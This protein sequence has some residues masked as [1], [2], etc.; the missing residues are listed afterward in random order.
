VKLTDTETAERISWA[1]VVVG[2]ALT[3]FQP[4][5]SVVTR[6]AILLATICACAVA[7]YLRGEQAADANRRSRWDARDRQR[8]HEQQLAQHAETQAGL[9]DVEKVLAEANERLKAAPTKEDVA[10]MVQAA[11]SDAQRLAE[12]LDRRIKAGEPATSAGLQHLAH[13]TATATASIARLSTRDVG[14]MSVEQ[15]AAM[16]AGEPT[17]V[18]LGNIFQVTSQPLPPKTTPILPEGGGP[19]RPNS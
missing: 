6:A 8:K 12:E 5:Q 18:T 11:Y 13:V 14:A 3:L 16:S 7:A 4:T 1:M 19:T 10:A 15:A 9:L 2:V 17:M